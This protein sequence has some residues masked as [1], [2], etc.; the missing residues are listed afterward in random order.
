[1]KFWNN[2][3]YNLFVIII[4]NHNRYYRKCGPE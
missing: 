2:S 1:V 4:V 3:Q